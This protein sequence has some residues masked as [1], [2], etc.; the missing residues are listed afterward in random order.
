MLSYIGHYN[1]QFLIYAIALYMT[2]VV[3]EVSP[4]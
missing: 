4:S 1:T 3:L 2:V